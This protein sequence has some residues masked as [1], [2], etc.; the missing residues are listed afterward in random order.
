MEA[1]R[2]G[3]KDGVKM[4]VGLVP[5]FALAAFFEGFITR[6]YKMPLWLSLSILTVSALFIT[7]YFVLY[8]MRSIQ[9]MVWNQLLSCTLVVG[10]ACSA[11][12]L[13]GA[14]FTYQ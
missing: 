11:F 8:P 3:T 6:Y 13:L 14:V 12:F 9:K 5:V 10:T 2:E 4:V 7:W 1:F